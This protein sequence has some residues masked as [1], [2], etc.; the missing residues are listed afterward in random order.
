MAVD[1]VALVHGAFADG[2]CWAKVIPLLTAR[3][4]DV[5][6]VQSPLTSLADDVTAER[7]NTRS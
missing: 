2:Y 4:L 7:S 6:A 5:I 1:R 3:D